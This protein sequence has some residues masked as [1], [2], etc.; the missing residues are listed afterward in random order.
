MGTIQKFRMT[1]TIGNELEK[2]ESIS[3][4]TH[5]LSQENAEARLKKHVEKH[6]KGQPIYKCKAVRE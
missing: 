5:A 4:V 3:F 1:I 2:R 6:Y